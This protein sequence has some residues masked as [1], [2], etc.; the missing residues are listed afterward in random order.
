MDHFGGNVSPEDQEAEMADFT[1]QGAHPAPVSGRMASVANWAG[2]AMSLALIVGI[3]VWGYGVI[4]RDVSGVPVVQA[5]AGPM[6]IAPEDPGGTLADHQG[7][8]VNA[9]AGQGAAADPV[10]QVLLAPLA[11]GLQADDVAQGVLIPVPPRPERTAPEF[12]PSLARNAAIMELAPKSEPDSAQSDDPLMALAS[13]I[14]AQSKTLTP[15]APQAED[16][17]AAA[18]SRAMQPSPRPKR[19]PRLRDTQA[20]VWPVRCARNCGP[21][22]CPARRA[23]RPQWLPPRAP[24]PNCRLTRCPLARALCRSVPLIA[25]TL[26]ARNGSG[27][28]GALGTTSTANPA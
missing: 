19:W 8:A 25:P 7:L 20:R 13:Q 16:E 3:G 17:V 27:W 28:R 2:A 10:D 18:I 5:L 26:R 22:V 12:Q 4:S 24:C 11:A 21:P 15:L 14:A 23:P 1:Y 9:V 6:R